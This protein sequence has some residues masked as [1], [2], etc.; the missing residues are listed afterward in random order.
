MSE[1][2]LFLIIGIIAIAIVFAA[3][4]SWKQE[5]ERT[6]AIGRVVGRLR[7]RFSGQQ[8]DGDFSERHGQFECFQRGHSR[9]AHNQMEGSLEGLGA[10]LNA[11]AGDYHYQITRGSGKNRNTTTYRFSY[12][13]IALPCG[14]RMPSLALRAEG[15]WDKLA[16]AVGFEDID[17][18]SAEFSRRYHVSGSDRRFAY[19]LIHPRMIDWMLDEAPP[20]FEISHG[21]LLIVS[22]GAG[23]R[24]EPEEF[25]AA[26]DWA[27]AFFSH[28]PDYLVRDLG[29][30]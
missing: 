30:R 28:W 24:W 10:S 26:V 19:D 12:L 15:L 16:G 4:F 29:A 5:R 18:E 20:Q 13:L 23:E 11:E 21:V 2:G 17:F 1:A 6:E 8:K 9:Y 3:W 25:Q 14:S 7:W 22:N 27:Q